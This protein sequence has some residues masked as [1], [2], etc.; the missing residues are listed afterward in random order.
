MIIPVVVKYF[1]GYAAIAP[2]AATSE[3][4]DTSDAIDEI[5]IRRSGDDGSFE[6]NYLFGSGSGIDKTV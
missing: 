2:A 1:N 5:Y 4:N 6:W 3:D